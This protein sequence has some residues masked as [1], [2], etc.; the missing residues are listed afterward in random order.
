MTWWLPLITGGV[1]A[2]LLLTLQGWQQRRQR[3]DAVSY[4]S[5]FTQLVAQ[6]DDVTHTV[7]NMA[8]QV[9]EAHERG[10]PK[11]LDYYE[12]TLRVVETVLGAVAKMP[13]F[14]HGASGLDSA[15]FLVNDCRRR[16]GRLSQAFEDLR[17]DRAVDLDTLYGVPPMALPTVRGCY[18][19]SRPVAEDRQS[20]VK[21]RLDRDVKAVTSCRICREELEST[22]KVKVLYFMRD[23]QQ[24]HWSE[25]KDYQ[26]SDD[27][28][29][30]NR[31]S[32]V[33][34]TRH[35]E[36]VPTGPQA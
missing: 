19:C 28:W 36:V 29:D 9:R 30:L 8:A 12:G 34:R 7:N 26:P 15:F 1:L 10:A 35:L 25:V 6:L 18:F 23:G 27:F 3:R 14:G 11:V 21:V 33:R 20:K 22:K 17:H 13:A 32:T 16:L 4:R 5:R 24:V 2:V 31:R